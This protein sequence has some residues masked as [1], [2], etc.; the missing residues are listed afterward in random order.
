VRTLQRRRKACESLELGDRGQEGKAWWMWWRNWLTR[1]EIA[2]RMTEN[3]SRRLS[4]SGCKPWFAPRGLAWTSLYVMCLPISWS[5][6]IR[7]DSGAACFSLLLAPLPLSLRFFT[8]IL[9]C[10]QEC[11][12][13]SLL[14]PGTCVQGFLC[15]CLLSLFPEIWNMSICHC[16]NLFSHIKFPKLL[17][18]CWVGQNG[19]KPLENVH[20]VECNLCWIWWPLL[21]DFMSGVFCGQV[22][23][24]FYN[25][26][27][28]W[29]KASK[30]WKPWNP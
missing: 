17:C 29:L 21:D 16:S 2:C 24:L 6:W 9:P 11:Y 30:R 14:L 8:I 1:S 13:L 27:L 3:S 4:W 25:A 20:E 23:S 22:Q 18:P 10:L 28:Q 5:G 7:V 12:V 19:F 26:L 15:L